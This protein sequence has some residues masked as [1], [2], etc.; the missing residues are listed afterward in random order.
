[1][2]EVSSAMGGDAVIGYRKPALER[3][4]RRGWFRSAI[5][6][7]PRVVVSR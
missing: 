5:H 7:K 4:A 1:V 6:G 3:L 2:V